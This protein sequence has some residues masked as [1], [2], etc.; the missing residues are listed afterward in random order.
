MK[1]QK[2]LI[3]PRISFFIS[4]ELNFYC[5]LYIA[6]EKKLY[7]KLAG[8]KLIVEKREIIINNK[9]KFLVSLLCK[10]LIPKCFE[11]ILRTFIRV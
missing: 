11:I 7:Q 8:L 1:S 5:S 10:V 6:L 9:E 3:P 2:E 4:H